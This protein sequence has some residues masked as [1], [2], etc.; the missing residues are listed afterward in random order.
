MQKLLTFFSKTIIVY[1]MFNDQSFND[2][3]A[4]SYLCLLKI[5]VV[6]MRGTLNEFPQHVFIYGDIRTMSISYYPCLEVLH[7]TYVC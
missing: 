2:K 1:A 7:P 4:K 5:Y 6:D 3:G